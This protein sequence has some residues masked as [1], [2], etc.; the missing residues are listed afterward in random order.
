MTSLLRFFQTLAVAVALAGS[1]TAWALDLPQGAK[2][3]ASDPQDSAPVR[4]ATSRFDGETV[5]VVTAEG[6]V[7]WQAW[8]IGGTSRTSF[9]ILVD[10]RDQ[11]MTDGYDILFQ[12]QAVSCGG[13]DF[14]FDIGHFSAPEMYVDLGD[15]HYLS[16]QKGDQ[17]VSLLVSRSSDSAF[18]ELA[19]VTPAGETAAQISSAQAGGVATPSSKQPSGSIGSVLET[20]GR[21]VLDGLQFATGSSQLQD[22][23]VPVLA[24]LARYLAQNPN[25]KI[26][27][28]G[29]TDAEGSLDGNIALSRKRATSVMST[30]SKLYGVDPSQLS[31]QG[32]GF[33][34]PLSA[35][36]TDEGRALNRRV[37]A[38]LTSTD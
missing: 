8:K 1:G 6:Q 35:N 19:Q 25:R 12:C 20:S 33:L 31:A 37:E 21:T 27:L 13:Y 4:V 15:Y 38:V 3:Q 36:L 34:M 17:Y 5:P 22:E 30:L 9:Q 14:R 16:A 7:T 24:D 23:D 2:L 26:V 29:H 10:L 28:V 11:L 18:V 32:V